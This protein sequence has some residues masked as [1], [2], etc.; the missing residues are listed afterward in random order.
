[1]VPPKI[2]FITTTG[3]ERLNPNLYKNG[4]LCLSILNTW[5]G[6]GWTPSNTIRS[7]L[8]TILGHIFVKYPLA[9][10]P[11]YEYESYKDRWFIYNKYIIS[12]NFYTAIN[13]VLFRNM[14]CEKFRKIIETY[15]FNHK[16]W[17]L[18]TFDKLITNFQG[19]NLNDSTYNNKANS[20]FIK[21]KQFFTEYLESTIVPSISLMEKLDLSYSNKK[22]YDFHEL[23][24]WKT[25]GKIKEKTKV[26]K[27]FDDLYFSLF[28]GGDIIDSKKL[29][30]FTVSCL[31]KICKNNKL[32]GYSKFRKAE[33]IEHIITN[34]EK[35]IK[36]DIAVTDDN[37][38]IIINKFVDK[39]LDLALKKLNEPKKTF[40]TKLNINIPKH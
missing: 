39:V 24:G 2:K 20:D 26:N 10:E 21:M 32:R 15:I 8:M 34:A 13:D 18:T 30:K 37:Q 29:K 17:Y 9:N 11:G 28:T 22:E 6:P 25:K 14:K 12:H 3:H 23:V 40:K 27:N 16:E 4:K 7:V 5:H 1:M 31:R 33:L 38:K 19:K 35:L 36:P